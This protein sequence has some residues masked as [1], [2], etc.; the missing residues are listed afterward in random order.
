MTPQG[1]I[2]KPIPRQPIPENDTRLIPNVG[3]PPASWG[4]REELHEASYM[5]D[6]DLNQNKDMSRSYYGL[7]NIPKPRI[8]LRFPSP[9]KKK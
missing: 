7:E 4:G 2:K 1:K 8:K 3:K 5:P 6:R 9:E